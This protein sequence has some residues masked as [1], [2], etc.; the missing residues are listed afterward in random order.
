MVIVG[1]SGS[2]VVARAVRTC[3]V[4]FIF[5]D[6]LC[7]VICKAMGDR[8]GNERPTDRQTDR[9]RQREWA[10]ETGQKERKRQT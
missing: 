1:I 10:R 8:D 5:G 2:A 9:Q 4:F 6:K 3:Y 7:V